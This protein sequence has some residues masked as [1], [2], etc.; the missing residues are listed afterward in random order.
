MVDYANELPDPRYTDGWATYI[1]Q[2]LQDVEHDEYK[3]RVH[4]Q[5]GDLSGPPWPQHSRLSMIIAPIIIRKVSTWQK[6]AMSHGAAML[7]RAAQSFRYGFNLTYSGLRLPKQEFDINKD[8]Y[9]LKAL[10][11]VQ[12]VRQAFGDFLLSATA[13]LISTK[14]EINLMLLKA[15]LEGYL[16]H[17][18]FDLLNQ[19]PLFAGS[20]MMFVMDI[21][22]CLG[23]R[24][25]T[26][27]V[28]FLGTSHV[29][30]ELRQLNILEN[31]IP[32]L[33]ALRDT[34]LDTAFFGKLP[35][36]KLL[37]SWEMFDDPLHTEQISAYE[38]RSAKN[39]LRNIIDSF[40]LMKETVME[41]FE[42]TNRGQML[43]KE[44][45]LGCNQRVQ[46]ESF[47]LF[48]QIYNQKDDFR[49]PMNDETIA[50]LLMKRNYETKWT[51]RGSAKC[52]G[53][54][55]G[56]CSRSFEQFAYSDKPTDGLEWRL[57]VIQDAL[58]EEFAQPFPLITAKLLQIWLC[59]DKILSKMI[60]QGNFLKYDIP[61]PD[62]ACVKRCLKSCDRLV[63]E[64]KE[65]GIRYTPINGWNVNVEKLAKDGILLSWK[66]AFREH[67]GGTTLADFQ[68]KNI[69]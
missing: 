50:D 37:K 49:D 56:F 23:M 44:G 31:K 34:F 41:N 52:L 36:S 21:A 15:E 51:K 35:N 6:L 24:V 66:A 59:C 55:D 19:H 14:T 5:Q 57:A 18:R 39:P 9:R 69:S 20:D 65:N 10:I 4:M 46:A 13:A 11:F 67:F 3:R 63:Q 47:S 45:R 12:E 58:V 7:R 28:T 29:Y 32:A 27:R 60:Q 26:Y 38:Y 30:N 17:N 33:E 1:L 43:M 40:D 16:K 61:D 22:Y 68:W 54:P 62:R 48:H 42:T 2:V 53:L 25:L 8:N 64:Q